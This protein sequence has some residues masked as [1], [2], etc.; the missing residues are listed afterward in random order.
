MLLYSSPNPEI[1]N[2]I[3]TQLRFTLGIF[4]AAHPEVN[5]AEGSLS[6]VVSDG[7]MQGWGVV[8]C[9]IPSV[10]KL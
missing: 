2:M 6:W 7:W 9:V 10:A 8:P 4:D 5:V 1:K 3:K